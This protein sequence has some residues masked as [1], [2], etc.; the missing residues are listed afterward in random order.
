VAGAATTDASAVTAL[1]CYSGSTFSGTVPYFGTSREHATPSAIDGPSRRNH[2]QSTVAERDTR[3]CGVTRAHLHA[4]TSPIVAAHRTMDACP[5]MRP[6][7]QSFMRGFGQV[8]F[9]DG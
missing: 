4:R 3:C 6:A 8:A 2:Q 5:P 7:W 9:K 1:I